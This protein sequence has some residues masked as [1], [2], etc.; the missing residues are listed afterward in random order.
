MLSSTRLLINHNYHFEGIFLE[1]YTISIQQKMKIDFYFFVVVL[2]YFIIFGII[3]L[4]IIIQ[5]LSFQIHIY[6]F[7]LLYILYFRC[8]INHNNFL[9]RF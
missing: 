9:V 4:F 3:C 1:L 8:F 2:L 7:F 5:I 6:L